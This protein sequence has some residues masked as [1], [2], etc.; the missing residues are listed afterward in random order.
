L[1]EEGS[2]WLQPQVVLDQREHHFC[3]HTIN[4]VLVDW[5]DTTPADV[6][7]DP[8]NIMQQFPHLKP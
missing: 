8:T 3:H 1:D 4:E 2:I 6:T 5:K 7:W